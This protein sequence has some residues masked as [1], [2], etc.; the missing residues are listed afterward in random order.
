M[1]TTPMHDEMPAPK[2]KTVDEAETAKD[3]LVRFL[4]HMEIGQNA[5]EKMVGIANGYI[6]H[7]KGAIGS[8]VII[9]IN[10]VY[11]DLNPLWLLTGEGE[12]LK[13][14]GSITGDS[15]S[16]GGLN[17]SGNIVGQ[18]HGDIHTDGGKDAAIAALHE[19]SGDCLEV[20]RDE[21]NQ[22][23]AKLERKDAYIREILSDSFARNQENMQRI[24][25]LINMI[26]LQNDKMHDHV[27]RI[28]EQNDRLFV[29]LEK[30]NNM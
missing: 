7:S 6:S 8:K 3:R 1:Q 14:A 11:P 16:M 5:F 26:A 10:D 17:G 19:K 22:F 2:E 9:K 15:L 30:N 23:H 28:Q 18:I 27:G 29:L 24:D 21:L 13:A 4:A 20:L 25:K 12:M